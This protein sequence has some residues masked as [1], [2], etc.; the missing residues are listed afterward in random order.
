MGVAIPLAVTGL[1]GLEW[2]WTANRGQLDISMRKQAELAAAAFDHW[3]EAERQPLIALAAS[4][5]ARPNSQPLTSEELH[6]VMRAHPNW[7]ALEARDASDRVVI[8]HPSDRAP[9]LPDLAASL[10]AELTRG[11]PSAIEFNWALGG[12]RPV[13]VVAVLRK[14]GGTLSALVDATSARDVIQD[15]D[16]PPG[17]VIVLFDRKRRIVQRIPDGDAFVG[18]DRS[19]SPAF[20]PLTRER[21]VVH[22][23]TSAT[24]GMRRVYGLARVG[25]TGFVVSVGVPSAV[26][27]EPARAQFYRYLLFSLI[28]LASAIVASLLIARRIAVPVR[29]LR[30]AALHLAAGDLA[31]RAPDL[32]TGEMGELSRVFNTMAGALEQRAAAL[33]E[34]D[35]LKSDFVSGVS[36]ELRTPLTTIKTLT[37][38]LQRGGETPE[39]R[40]RYLE[41]IASE[42]DRQID[43]VL[44]LLD[45]SRIEAGAFTLTSECVDLAEVVDACVSTERFAAEAAGCEIA[46]DLPAELPYVRAERAALRRVLRC[47]V[48]NAVKYTPPGG[49]VTVSA[50][51]AD[52]AVVVAVT[53]TGR[54]IAARDLPHIF[55]RFYRSTDGADAEPHGVGLGLY[56][57]HTIVEHLGGRLS[58]ESEVGRGST[59]SVS[60]PRWASDTAIRNPAEESLNA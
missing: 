55:E 53:D 56:L 4:E 22:E 9:L 41:A 32:G 45:V 59:F 54:G 25:T 15:I 60:L 37:Q 2:V 13:L 7:L 57:A 5:S 48:E 39:E 20:E 47:L 36:H 28:A 3:I 11:E 8:S 10:H 52:G 14:D 49:R 24:D 26:L 50:R 23:T 58:V 33:A 31:A 27:Y 29:H 17:G 43:F 6:S 35:R 51:E 12:S 18:A 44:D 42:C 1:V 30:G 46:T 21:S 40:R 38:V 19:E 16:L 34:L